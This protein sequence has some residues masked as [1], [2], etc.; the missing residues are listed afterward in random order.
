MSIKGLIENQTIIIDD[1]KRGSKEIKDWDNQTND[2]HI[3]KTT[4]YPLD[5]K[6]QHIRIRIPIN[7]QR[8]I[9]IENTRKENL[10]NI[11]QKLKKEIKKAFENDTKRREFI[12]DIIVVLKDFKTALETEQ[13]AKQVLENLSKHFELEWTG[14]KIANH[15][16]DI[17]MDYSEEFKDSKG[18]SFFMKIDT[19]KIEIGENSGHVKQFKKINRK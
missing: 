10:S 19:E 18:K 12:N 16:N 6:L 8:P 7:S 11:P 2:I 15:V 13:R 17:L 14:E 4:N 9:K 1:H 5:G 3:D